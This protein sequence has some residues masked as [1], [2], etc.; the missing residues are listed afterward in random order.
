MKI[1]SV[2]EIASGAHSSIDTRR[3]ATALFEG[4][5]WHNIVMKVSINTLVRGLGFIYLIAFLSLVSQVIPLF[6]EQGIVPLSDSIPFFSKQVQHK[7]LY[8]P[9][10]FWFGVS[11]ELL[12]GAVWLGVILS[13]VMIAGKRFSWIGTLG[14]WLLYVSFVNLGAPFMSF[15]WDVLLVE[16]GFLA[17]LVDVGVAP[18]VIV[19]AFRLLVFRVMFASGLV[20]LTSGDLLW[21]N[22][23]AM[24]VHY[25][26]QPIPHIGGW[27][28]DKLPVWFQ[29]FST[30]MVFVIELIIPFFMFGPKRMKQ[31]C[32]AVCIGLMGLIALTGNYTFFNLLVILLS[33]SIV[34]EAPL[35]PIKK[36]QNWTWRSLRT[37][38]ALSLIVLG[39]THEIVRFVP[40]VK[41][42][43][44]G[45]RRV[46]SGW[47][48]INGYGLFAVMTPHR[49]EI[50]I[51][52]SKDG[53]EWKTYTFK[54]KPEA[55]NKA[56]QWIWPHQPRL[57][58]QMWFASLSTLQR[59]FWLQRFA[60]KLL[61]G[62]NVVTRL[63]EE[64]PF[65]DSPPEMIK[66]DRY[67]YT[68]SSLAHR[69]ETGD[70]WQ[71]RYIGAYCY[72]V[73]LPRKILAD[74]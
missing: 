73:S 3:E 32:A 45:L 65:S 43:F 58:W 22:F 69:Q 44:P 74:E 66:M 35:P 6:G 56:P 52:G 60:L 33:F 64:N 25:L 13:L 18:T 63:L 29:R 49:D 16:A 19:W 68:Y 34:I 70:W 39:I 20:K 48:L 67:R 38:I 59:T 21:R 47:R 36:L 41:E 57:D 23:E 50:S 61:E 55:L 42:P 46:V 14:V 54:Y 40:V 26:T 11:D 9:S 37:G 7:W 24:S 2:G 53:H 31:V 27:Y 28:A 72:P 71:R 1:A 17:L 8:L 10:L 62:N 4:V 5:S 30:V 12:K 51:L 15:Q